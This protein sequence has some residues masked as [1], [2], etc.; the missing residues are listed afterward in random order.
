MVR[1]KDLFDGFFPFSTSFICLFVCLLI[2]GE[3]F[4]ELGYFGFPGERNIFT[5]QNFAPLCESTK[6]GV[7]G[8]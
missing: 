5:R 7:E 1:S 8:F 6:F 2:W 4:E 3:F